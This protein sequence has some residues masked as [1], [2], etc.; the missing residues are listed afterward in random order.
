MQA[1]KEKRRP[2]AWVG[3]GTRQS[4]TLLPVDQSP[5]GRVRRVP[6]QAGE[7]WVPL[8][9]KSAMESVGLSRVHRTV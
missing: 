9:V 5:M 6:S 3:D 1:K 4:I 2:G 7:N 8:Y